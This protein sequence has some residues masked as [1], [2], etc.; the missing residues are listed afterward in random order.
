M[1]ETLGEIFATTMSILSLLNPL[2]DSRS[3]ELG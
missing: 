3:K 1:E 2:L